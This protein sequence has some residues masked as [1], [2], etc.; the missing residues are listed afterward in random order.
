ML[1]L[2][3]QMCKSKDISDFLK[4]FFILF[5]YFIVQKQSKSRKLISTVKN[6]LFSSQ[7]NNKYKLIFPKNNKYEE[8]LWIK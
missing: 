5:N 8:L 3:S 1:G 7:I 6:T 4:Y 2:V